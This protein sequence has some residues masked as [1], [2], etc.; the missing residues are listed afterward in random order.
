[1]THSY[2]EAVLGKCVTDEVSKDS[3]D[4]ETLTAKWKRIKA[5]RN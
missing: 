2:S 3:E 4:T 5:I 1:M